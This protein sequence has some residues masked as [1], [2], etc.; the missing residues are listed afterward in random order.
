MNKKTPA[1]GRGFLLPGT[2]GVLLELPVDLHAE[3]VD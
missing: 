3:D 2:Q 1:T